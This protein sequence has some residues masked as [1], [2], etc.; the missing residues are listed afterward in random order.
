MAR[1]LTARELVEHIVVKARAIAE[2]ADE[3]E[4]HYDFSIPFLIRK[5]S[6]SLGPLGGFAEYAH[7]VIMS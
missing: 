7:R 3:R 6:Y 1:D 4:L 2:G 5:T